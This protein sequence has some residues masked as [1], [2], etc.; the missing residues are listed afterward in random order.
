MKAKFLFSLLAVLFSMA[1]MAQSP[2]MLNYQA[3]LRNSAGDISQNQNVNVDFTIH[4]GSPTGPSVYSEMHNTTTNEY[5]LVNL[6][7]GKGTGATGNFANIDWSSNSYFL[8]VRV[9]G[10]NAG[11]QELASVPYSLYA[12]RA[13][14]ADND[15]DTDPANEIQTISLNGAELTLSN[16]GGTLTLPTGTTYIAGSGISI[17]GNTISAT[18]NSTTNELQQ[19]NISG[20]QLS[21]TNGNTVTLPTGMVGPQ[22]PAGPQGPQ[23]IPGPQGPQ[24]DPG[25]QGP[26]GNTGP[27]G[28]AGPQGP[29]GN[30]GPQGP[31][32]TG[33][34]IVGSV[35]SAAGLPFPY[36]GSIGD[37]YIS[38]ND[39]HGHVWNG[40]SW[41]DVG[42][43]QGPAGPA[44]PA[45]A[46][47]A[48][49]PAGPVGPTGPIGPTGPAGTYTAGSG[50]A[51]AGDVIS[52]TDNST[53]NE[54][55]TISLSGTMLS[56]SNGGGSVTLPTGGAGQWTPS[57]MDISNINTGNVGVGTNA[58]VNKLTVIGAG[59]DPSIPGTAST[60]IARIGVFNN[61]GVDIGKMANSPFAGWIQSGFDGTDADPLALQPAGG[62]VGI[63]KTNPVSLLDVGNGSGTL[64]AKI[65]ASNSNLAL[66]LDYNDDSPGYEFFVDNALG[67]NICE[68]GV[69]CDRL[70]LQKNTGNLG[71]G[72]N[73]PVDKLYVKSTLSNRVTI[74][75]DEDFFAGYRSKIPSAEFF[76]GVQSD[77]GANP[78]FSIYDNLADLERLTILNNGNV[79]INNTEPGDYKLAIQHESYGMQLKNV[80][81]GTAFWEFFQGG[82]GDLFLFTEAANVGNFNYASGMYSA[83]SDRRLKRN[84]Q[85][86]A[87]VLPSLMKLEATSYFYATDKEQKRNIGF[88]AQDVEPLFPELVT[89]PSEEPGRNTNYLMNYAGF[90]VLAVKAVQEQQAI[91][92][93]QQAAIETLKAENKT[94]QAKLDAIEKALAK[95][96]ISLD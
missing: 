94:Q 36:A 80:A 5:G 75:S 39:G 73:S 12:A 82:S 91:I 1:A 68:S 47:G 30:T 4:S 55:Q 19:L 22:G 51:I 52:A 37:M 40:A 85:P 83:T 59:N 27:Q 67:L 96:G 20:D 66:R 61:E 64:P 50:I 38:Q 35:A 34:Q 6:Q 18:D 89:P 43:I 14:S 45:G 60:G 58:P 49:G 56:L 28:P 87:S 31:A 7:I 74:E 69:A 42:Q 13:G 15:N 24:G 77:L 95:A 3:V 78:R 10:A 92:E 11:T 26:Q 86:L 41:D 57:G 84:I 76:A 71:I 16:G 72:T 79:G 70:F 65:R 93:A 25:P 8:Q 21:L 2:E 46:T 63:G 90:G 29:Q 9:D 32:G 17:S 54:I 33:V 48:T 53:T 23:G 88:I 62:N 81:A 44:G